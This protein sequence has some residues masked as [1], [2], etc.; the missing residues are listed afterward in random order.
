[1][2]DIIFELGQIVYV[3]TDIDQH[4]RMVTAISIRGNGVTYELT[5]GTITSWHYDFEI[6]IT[7][8]VLLSTS[9]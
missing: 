3:K 8:D 7:K 6:N 5:C 4:K 1:M 9:E 2:K